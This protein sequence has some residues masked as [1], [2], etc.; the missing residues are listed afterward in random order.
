[1]KPFN[2]NRDGTIRFGPKF[3]PQHAPQVGMIDHNAVIMGSGFPRT[4]R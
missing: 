1:M 2:A 4:C 3:G